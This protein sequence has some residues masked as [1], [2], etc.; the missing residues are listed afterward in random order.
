ML[1]FKWKLEKFRNIYS[2]KYKMNFKNDF[3]QNWSPFRNQCS[4][5][6]THL[7]IITL[8][9]RSRISSFQMS[10]YS[11]FKFCLIFLVKKKVLHKIIGTRYRCIRID[12][13]YGSFRWVKM[14]S[15]K[16]CYKYI[17]LYLMHLSEKLYKSWMFL[18][19]HVA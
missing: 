15:C 2:R 7:G 10:Q 12:L 17:Y 11:H 13:K 3:P 9:D 1:V 4:N 8:K 14:F 16:I 18:S 5:Y 19:I 6:A